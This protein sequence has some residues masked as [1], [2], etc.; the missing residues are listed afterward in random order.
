MRI[1]KASFHCCS[2]SVALC[3]DC[4]FCNIVNICLCFVIEEKEHKFEK[5]KSQS[6]NNLKEIIEARDENKV[7][8]N[9]SGP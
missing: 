1:N 2:V 6:R 9:L 3:S 7:R 4:C 5:N 8:K